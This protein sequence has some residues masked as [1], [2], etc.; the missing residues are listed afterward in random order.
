MYIRVLKGRK[1]IGRV[2]REKQAAVPMKTS[3]LK[4]RKLTVTT[5][6]RCWWTQTNSF[7]YL[8]D[9][10]TKRE[11]IKTGIKKKGDRRRRKEELKHNKKI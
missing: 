11:I 3:L 6:G 5:R 2:A 10:K 8:R 4:N 9:L 7:I 1:W